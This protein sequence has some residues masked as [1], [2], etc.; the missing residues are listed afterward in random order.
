M[1]TYAEIAKARETENTYE[2][3]QV[4]ME[5][6]MDNLRKYSKMV[7]IEG[8]NIKLVMPEEEKKKEERKTSRVSFL[9]SRI[10]SNH[11]F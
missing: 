10:H 6:D 2:I 5:C 3:E 7:K 11:T 8:T 4:N 9:S 1:K